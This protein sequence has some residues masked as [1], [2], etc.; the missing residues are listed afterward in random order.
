M[1]Q[2]GPRLVLILYLVL[3]TILAFYLAKDLI[4][5]HA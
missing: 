4:Y 1:I 2:F 5:D 3:I